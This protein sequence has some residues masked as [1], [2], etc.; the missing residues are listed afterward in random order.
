MA[1]SKF[2]IGIE[3]VATYLPD[4]KID[5]LDQA[6]KFGLEDGFVSSKIGALSLPRFGDGDDVVSAC[7]K[8]FEQLQRKIDILSSDIDCIVVCTQTPDSDG[9]PHSSALV[10]ATLGVGDNCA[11]F[12]IGLGCSGY[13]Y[14]LQIV[15]SFMQMHGLSK[16]LFFTCDPYSKILDPD[17]KNTSL[18]FGDAASVTLLSDRAVL[19]CKHVE[20]ATRGSQSDVLNKRNGLLC[21]NGRAVFNFALTDVPVQIK[22][23]LEKSGLDQELVDIFLLHQGSRFMLENVIKRAGVDPDKAPVDLVDTGNTVSSSI[24]ILLERYMDDRSKRIFVMS[25]FG[26]GL[27]WATAIYERAF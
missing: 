25:G 21:M 12:D 5:N 8:A 1:K 10:H 16:G 14:G 3:A 15:S 23:T 22:S 17:D 19:Q 13:V 11:C 27:S 18:L 7:Q 6:R 24:P 20:F 26:V 9:I 4:Q 2:Q